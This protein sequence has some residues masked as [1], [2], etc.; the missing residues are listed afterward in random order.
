MPL[1]T[2]H[3]AIEKQIATGGCRIRCPWCNGLNRDDGEYIAGRQ[4]GDPLCCDKFTEAVFEIIT[5]AADGNA[6]YPARARQASEMI[7]IKNLLYI[8][9][10]VRELFRAV[11][12]SSKG[13]IGTGLHGAVLWCPY[14]RTEDGRQLGNRFGNPELCC[15]DL[16]EA[17]AGVLAKMEMRRQVDNAARI[18]ENADRLKECGVT[19]Q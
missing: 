8:E 2:N 10:Q 9:S 11:K 3:L 1:T 13:E 18:A 6:K 4:F 5:Q 17:I 12:S 7:E 14:C 19:V 15:F 16:G